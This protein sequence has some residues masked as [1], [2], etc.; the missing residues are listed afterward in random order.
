MDRRSLRAAI[1]QAV[2]FCPI[3]DGDCLEAEDA[4]RIAKVFGIGPRAVLNE[5]RRMSVV[6]DKGLQK[7]G[8]A[9]EAGAT[10]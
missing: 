6:A 7:R 9:K 8:P 10:V 4:D 5:Y 2:H 1:Q 3:S